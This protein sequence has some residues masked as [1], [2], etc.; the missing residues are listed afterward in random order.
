MPSY[1]TRSMQKV[2]KLISNCATRIWRSVKP[3]LFKQMRLEHDIARPAR[4]LR[5]GFA[6]AQQLLQAL[7]R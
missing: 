5:P 3:L 1:N 7:E 4:A 2:N 6:E